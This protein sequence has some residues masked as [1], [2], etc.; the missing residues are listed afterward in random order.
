MKRFELPG[1]LAPAEERAIIA[2]LEQYFAPKDFGP[3]PWALAGR[4]DAT[5]FGALQARRQAG[6]AWRMAARSAFARPGVPT[7]AG[8]GDA[9]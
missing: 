8:R 7:F 6:N 9:R 2:A 3:S 5:G 4:L 1:G